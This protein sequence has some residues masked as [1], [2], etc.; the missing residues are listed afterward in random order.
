M[1]HLGTG[2]CSIPLD[3]LKNTNR[4]DRGATVGRGLDCVVS[5]NQHNDSHSKLYKFISKRH[6]LLRLSDDGL[7]VKNFELKNGT[8][9]NQTKLAE[10]SWVKL[11]ENDI[12]SL[13]WCVL[14]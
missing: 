14:S 6:A 2:L 8:F 1:L 12:I 3:V 11:H 5:I 10:D 13:G 4:E 9:V 7:Y